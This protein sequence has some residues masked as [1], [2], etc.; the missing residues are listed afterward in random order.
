M[1]AT[2][3]ARA[4]LLRSF[5]AATEESSRSEFEVWMK[6]LRRSVRKLLLLFSCLTGASA[7]QDSKLLR[8]CIAVSVAHTTPITGEDQA[9]NRR[10]NRRASPVIAAKNAGNAGYFVSVFRNAFF[11]VSS[12]QRRSVDHKR[13]RCSEQACDRIAAIVPH[14]IGARRQDRHRGVGFEQQH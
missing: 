13:S 3:G 10:N 14:R 6:S 12:A 11:A 1:D 5:E 2:N 7:G 8:D 9:D 4:F